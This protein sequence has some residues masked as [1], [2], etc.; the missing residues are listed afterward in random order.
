MRR[1][2]SDRRI[3]DCLAGKVIA[4]QQNAVQQVAFTVATANAIDKGGDS[5]LA[6]ASA[7]NRFQ[8]HR[9]TAPPRRLGSRRVADATS[10]ISSREEHR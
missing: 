3:P 4:P 7:F 6:S 2:R 8:R 5:W 9:G 1:S 10:I